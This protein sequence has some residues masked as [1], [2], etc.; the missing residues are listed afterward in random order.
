MNNIEKADFE[1]NFEEVPEFF[2]LVGTFNQ[3]LARSIL[4]HPFVLAFSH[5]TPRFLTVVYLA[6]DCWTLQSCRKRWVDQKAR[7]CCSVI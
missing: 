1:R 7:P 6:A 3:S 5:V 4:L 2:T